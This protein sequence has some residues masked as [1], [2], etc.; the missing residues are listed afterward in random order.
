[1][2]KSEYPNFT[3]EQINDKYITYLY[4]TLALEI[5]YQ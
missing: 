3:S 5:I 4:M 1:M 2:P